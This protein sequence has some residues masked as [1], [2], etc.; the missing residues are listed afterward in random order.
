MVDVFVR[1]GTVLM[2][3]L[4]LTGAVQHIAREEAEHILGELGWKTGPAGLRPPWGKPGTAVC[5]GGGAAN[6]AKIAALL[7]VDA[8]FIGSIGD[9]RP[10]ELFRREIAASGAVPLLVPGRGKTGL[11]IILSSPGG[12]TRIAAAPG[13]AGELSPEHIDEAAVKNAGTVLLDGRLLDR[14]P[15]IRRVLELAGRFGVPAALDAAS[16]FLAGERAEEILHYSRNYPLIVFMNG[17]EAIAFYRRLRGAEGAAEIRDEGEKAD[18]IIREVC[19]ALQSIAGTGQFPVFALKLGSRGAVIVAGG[20][21]CRA[22]VSPVKA[23]NSI[24]AGDA[25][26]A[27][28]LA[29]RLRGKSIAESAALGNRAARKILEVPGARIAR[30]QLASV[31]RSLWAPETPA[32]FSP[33]PTT[34]P[35][36]RLFPPPQGPKAC[37]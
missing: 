4:G 2:D 37:R 9:D 30:R 32:A 21:V 7:G 34:A 12:E 27:A 29:G 35:T 24:G 13:A 1:A 11:C 23:R 19:P 14:R 5:S 25:F 33:G 22:A 15:L 26:G 16:A 6:A 18:L 17:D 3:R 28:F 31:R 36:G 8:G 20:E 10:G